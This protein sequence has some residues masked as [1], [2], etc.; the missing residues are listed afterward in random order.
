[1][2]ESFMLPRLFLFTAHM[3]VFIEC[4]SFPAFVQI[5]AKPSARYGA[6]ERPFRH[7]AIEEGLR[8]ALRDLNYKLDFGPNPPL[9][10]IKYRP[11][12]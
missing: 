7:P 11:G 12:A 4:D 8:S 9:R 1:M 10:C 2:V 6:L 5:P 3:R